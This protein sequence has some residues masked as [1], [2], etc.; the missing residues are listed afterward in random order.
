MDNL[1]WWAALMDQL[2]F[3]TADGFGFEMSRI[4]TRNGVELGT[5]EHI[6]N[7]DWGPHPQK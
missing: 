7:K 2:D 5:L 4:D 1:P 3:T 6:G